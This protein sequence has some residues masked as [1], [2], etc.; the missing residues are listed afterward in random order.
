MADAVFSAGFLNTC[1]RHAETVQMANMAPVVNTRGPLFVH[2][3]GI[4]KRTT[5]HVLA[6]YAQH[7]LPNIVDTWVNS[8]PFRRGDK[9]V[10]ALDCVATCDDGMR[11][12]AIAVVNRDSEQDVACEINLGGRPLSGPVVATVLSGSD[13][14]AYNDIACPDHVILQETALTVQ[15]GKLSFPAHSVTVLQ[16]HLLDL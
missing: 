14:D 7:L 15:D 16:A 2:P 9:Q 10:P 5:F 12:W 3:Q 11:E 4:V 8:Q 1:L 13:P 6:M